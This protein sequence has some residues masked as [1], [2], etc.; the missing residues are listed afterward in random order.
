MT[1]KHA[2]KTLKLANASAVDNGTPVAIPQAAALA[3]L[4][5]LATHTCRPRPSNAPCKSSY[6]LA[7]RAQ[8]SAVQKAYW[9]PERRE[10]AR[11]KALARRAIVTPE[12]PVL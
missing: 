4:Q 7:Q 11:V 6:T 1:I 10:E 12:P 3:I 2:L 5:Y 8:M 9:T